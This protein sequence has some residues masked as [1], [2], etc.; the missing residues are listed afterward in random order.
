MNA[1]DI[2]I[3]AILALS[4][5]FGLMRGFVAEVLSLAC[6]IAAFAVAWLFGDAVAGWYEPWLREPFARIIAGYLTCFVGVLVVGAILGWILRRLIRSSGLS[7]ADR[8]LGMLFGLARG[9]LLVLVIV[10]VLNFTP[11][12]G[13]GWWDRSMLLPGFQ[14]CAGWLSAHLPADASRYVQNGERALRSGRQALSAL[15]VAPISVSRLAAPAVDESAHNGRPNAKS[16][17][18]HQDGDVGQ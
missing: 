1:A 6:W 15:P 11:L 10:A 7:G 8:L 4:V 13:A 3:L 9:V 16:S 12:A 14:Q 18:H 2:I 17:P 5:L